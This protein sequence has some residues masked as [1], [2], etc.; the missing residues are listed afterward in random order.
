MKRRKFIRDSVVGAS[1]ISIVPGTVLAQPGRVAPSDKLNIAVIGAGGRG[2][3]HWAGANESGRANVVALVDVDDKRAAGA[4][5][6]NP[7]AKR[8]KDYRKL[9]DIQDE[10][11]AVMVA[12]PD[13][14][15]GVIGTAMMDLGKHAYIEKPLAHSIY[16]VRM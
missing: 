8:F 4:Y 5:R 14:T 9:E 13:H 16:E 3:A 1:A 11:D 7:K 6:S 2:N 10:F 15:H 12:T